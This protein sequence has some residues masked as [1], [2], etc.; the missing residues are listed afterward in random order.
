M[1][2]LPTVQEEIQHR[3][4]YLEQHTSILDLH[5]MQHI[6]TA[7]PSSS[8]AR[9]GNHNPPPHEQKIHGL[10]LPTIFRG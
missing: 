2:T 3:F 7:P 5:Q 1:H 10:R 8:Q 4:P 6:G 9:S